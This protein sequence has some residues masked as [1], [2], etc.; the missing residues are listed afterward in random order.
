M[1]EGFGV[2]IILV[3]L[4]FAGGCYVGKAHYHDTLCK[5]RF[6]HATTAADTVV[7]ATDDRHCA[8]Y[9]HDFARP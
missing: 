5:E 1:S 9:L 6:V 7:V 4:A 8:K 3:A 2:A